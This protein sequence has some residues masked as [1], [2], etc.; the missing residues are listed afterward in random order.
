MN[1][2]QNDSSCRFTQEHPLEK[3]AFFPMICPL[4]LL[5]LSF[6]WPCSAF[7]Q[8]LAVAPVDNAGLAVDLMRLSA[9]K[10]LQDEDV[11]QALKIL[12]AVNSLPD[13]A[14]D[15]F[16]SRLSPASGALYRSLLQLGTDEQYELLH[17]WTLGE[18]ANGEVRVLLSL[19]PEIAPPME[20]ARAI[21]QRPGKDSFPI[22]TVGEMRGLFCS[23]WTLVVAADDSGNLRQLI[24]ELEPLAKKNVT[25]ASFVLSLARLKDSRTT[26][27]ELKTLLTARIAPEGETSGASLM[28]DAALVAAAMT[29]EGLAEQRQQI[30]ERLNQFNFASGSSPHVPFLKRLRATVILQNRSPETNPSDLLYQPPALWVA[31]DDQRHSGFATGAD[32][33]IWLSHE[34]HIQRLAG[35]GDDALLFRYP[36]TGKFELKGEATALDHGAAGM[37]YGGLGFEADQEVFT[38]RE[39]QRN[40]FELREWPFIAPR[41][42]RM[43]N[44]VNIRSEESSIKFLSNLHPGYNGSQ[45]SCAGAPWVGLRASGDGR[46]YFRNLELTGAPVI[47]RE[48]RISDSADLRGWIASYGELLPRAVTPFPSQSAKVLARSQQVPADAKPVWSVTE[49]VIASAV[50]YSANEAAVIQSHMAYVRPLLNGETLRYEF[51]YEEG[52]YEVHPTLGR[53]AFL[54]EAGGVRMHWLTDDGN[55][56]TGLAADNA[57]IEPLNRRGPRALPLKEGDWNQLTLKLV[58]GKASLELNGEQIYERAIGDLSNHHLGFY[59]DRARSTARV[60]NVVLSGQWPEKLTPEQMQ[61]LAAF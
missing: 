41:E 7:A 30:A 35:H 39:I 40:A 58:E 13:D 50:S 56:W 33:V 34:D 49:G 61:K 59:H 25:N 27:E 43:F 26:V 60:R 38:V 21:G 14:L 48:V 10:A 19:V 44:R 2:D 53:M 22:A 42:L 23:A 1:F 31:A 15:P 17:Q 11:S 5:F 57:I 29:R 37:L 52:K 32:R 55:E 16:R 8:T 9:L 46:I 47:P 51:F 36:L 18:N 54:I 45:A 3:R 12:E 6:A 4:A 28:Q 20:F 24:T